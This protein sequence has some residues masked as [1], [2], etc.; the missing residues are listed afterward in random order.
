MIGTGRTRWPMIWVFPEEGGSRT[1]QQSLNELKPRVKDNEPLSLPW[2]FLTQPGAPSPT[3][4]HLCSANCSFW[5][6]KRELRTLHSIPTSKKWE[7]NIQYFRDWFAFREHQHRE[8]NRVVIEKD[9]SEHYR[10]TENAFDM[11][12]EKQQ[13]SKQYGYH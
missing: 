7:I 11:L 6:A 12:S 10:N 9:Y 2:A 1:Q 4:L 5:G 8:R 3:R 13:N